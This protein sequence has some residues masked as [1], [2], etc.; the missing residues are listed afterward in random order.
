MSIKNSCVI[1]AVLAGLAFATSDARAAGHGS[2]SA[3][4]GAGGRM[5]SHPGHPGPF[6]HPRN[7]FGTP[8]CSFCGA[9]FGGF[10]LGYGFGGYGLGYGYPGWGYEYDF[11]SVP[12]FAAFPPVYYGYNGQGPTFGRAVPAAGVAGDVPQSAWETA[13]ASPARQPLIIKN[14]YYYAK[15]SSEIERSKG[16]TPAPESLAR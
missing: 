7:G 6:F 4:R 1:L 15:G 12:Y 3:G 2:P 16:E 10:G 14:P 13:H 9:G 5:G 8:F 11:G